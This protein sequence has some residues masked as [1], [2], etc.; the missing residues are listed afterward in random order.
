M[1]FRFVAAALSLSCAA[2]ALA[3]P[4]SAQRNSEAA[5]EIDAASQAFNACL[6]NNAMRADEAATPE[7]AAAAI[8]AACA[9]QRERL[10]NLIEAVMVTL[11]LQQQGTARER[12]RTSLASIEEGLTQSIR[13]SR[14]AA[15]AGTER[16]IEIS[17]EPP[18]RRD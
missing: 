4:Q 3:Q 11:P 8:V 5:A 15:P 6:V 2:S 17:V 14:A 1:M 12:L 18:V 16:Q 10:I 13:N 7:V 9:P